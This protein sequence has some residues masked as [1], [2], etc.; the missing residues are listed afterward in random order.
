MATMLS[1]QGAKGEMGNGEKVKAFG[2]RSFT[3]NRSADGYQRGEG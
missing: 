1:H 3:F 2:G